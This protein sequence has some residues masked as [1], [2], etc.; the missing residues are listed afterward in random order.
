MDRRYVFLQT[1]TVLV[2]KRSKGRGCNRIFPFAMDGFKLSMTL[3]MLRDYVMT[4]MMGA[5]VLFLRVL[6]H[7]PR[8]YTS[9]EV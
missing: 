4:K 5:Y 1:C 7:T 3:P 9:L 2:V 8:K 6:Y